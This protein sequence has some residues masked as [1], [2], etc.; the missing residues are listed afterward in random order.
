MV[1]ADDPQG[2]GRVQVLIASTGSER[3]AARVF[4]IAAFTAHDIAVG[5]GVWIAFEDDDPQWPVVLGLT[6]P[7][8]RRDGLARDLEAMG[9]AWDRGHASGTADAG[10]SV[11]P[12]P[13]R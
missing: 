10:G 11:T 2:Q 5:A 1:S 12:N 13:Y 9:D 4:P 7:P 6:D 3:W 8:S